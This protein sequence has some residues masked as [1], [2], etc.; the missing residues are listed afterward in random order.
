MI[1]HTTYELEIFNNIY[2]DSNCHNTAVKTDVKYGK[3]TASSLN[4]RKQ[5]S[6]TAKKCTFSPLPKNQKV[7]I[8]SKT[9]NWY[10]IEHNGKRGYVSAKYIA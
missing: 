10:L 6:V 4:V 7:K 1:I 8:I 9:G 5:P 2:S 3:V